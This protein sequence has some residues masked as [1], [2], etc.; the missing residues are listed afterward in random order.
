[1]TCVV[2]SPRG[3][4]LYGVCPI[5]GKVMA[6]C[7]WYRCQALNNA[8]LPLPSFVRASQAQ[9]EGMVTLVSKDHW[10]LKGTRETWV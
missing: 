10:D 1:M 5:P 8:P 3:D 6:S 7:I 9:K 2:Y 4:C